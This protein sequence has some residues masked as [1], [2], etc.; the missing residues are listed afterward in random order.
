MMRLKA[1]MTRINFSDF[2][3]N[4]PLSDLSTFRIGGNAE[5][6]IEIR[7]IPKLIEVLSFCK[8]EG[9]QVHIIGKGSN[10]LFPDKGLKGLVISNKLDFIENQNEKIS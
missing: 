10:S 1:N 4:K 3:K 9:V 7:E 6:F 8:V 5:Y 2:E